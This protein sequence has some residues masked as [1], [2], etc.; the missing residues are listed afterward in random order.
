[1]NLWTNIKSITQNSFRVILKEND[2][3]IREEG[4]EENI[5]F[6]WLWDIGK[7]I[8]PIQVWKYYKEKDREIFAPV[9]ILNSFDVSSNDA[10]YGAP[11][12][13]MLYKEGCI[14][15]LFWWAWWK[16]QLNLEWKNYRND[17]G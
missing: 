3:I 15:S 4:N 16:L 5:A 13:F 10:L 11:V 2:K 6:R 8:Q 12:S 14:I 17:S 9:L 1:M 7:E